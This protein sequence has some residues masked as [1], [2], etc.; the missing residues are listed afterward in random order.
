MEIINDDEMKWEWNEDDNDTGNVKLG[1]QDAVRDRFPENPMN[2]KSFTGPVL[3]VKILRAFKPCISGR[4][5]S[6]KV[7]PLCKS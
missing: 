6:D 2:R 4:G 5:N 1:E 7:H 3:R